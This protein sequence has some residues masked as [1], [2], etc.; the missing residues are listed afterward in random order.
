MARTSW[1]SVLFFGLCL[2]RLAL[3]DE[4]APIPP[5]TPQRI[6]QTVDRAI[7]YLQT[8]SAAWLSQRKCAAC[9]HVPMPLWALSE[10]G[11]QG[12]AIDRK[13]VADTTEAT[14]GSPEKMIAS[15]LVSGPN[16]PPDP[17]PMAKGVNTGQVFLA[18]VA[19]S[20]PSLEEG[21]KQSLKSITADIVK[22]QREDGSWEFFLSRP[23]VNENQATD[24]A[25][26]IMALQGETGPE[27]ESH[28]AS[29]E[30]GMTWLAG[31]E[32]R[33][34]Y[35]VKVLNLLVAIRAGKPRDTLQPRIDELFARQRPDGGWSQTPETMSDA[36][37]TGEILYVL[38]L[39]G[40]T[41][42]RS[43]IKRAI[44]FL[45]ATQKPDGSWPMIS[46]A[47]PDGKPGGGAKLL[48]PITC[49]ASSWA[50]LGLARLVPKGS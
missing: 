33:D 3:A 14:L 11:R 6:H 32:P 2:P 24:T 18:A 50:T 23:P 9:H 37:A 39:A 43:E 21:Q 30:K 19:R 47:S 45:V 1:L 44:D 40:Y 42:E 4:P 8:E 48:T 10:A 22:K 15:R 13:F 26:I 25:W 29:L 31:A 36:F 12:Y 35:Q 38:S 20:L 28:R 5:A 7:G 27:A 46:R 34:H 16:D 49:A 17:R 41:A